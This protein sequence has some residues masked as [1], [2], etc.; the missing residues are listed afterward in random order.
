VALPNYCFCFVFLHSKPLL[1]FSN[2]NVVFERKKGPKKIG[3]KSNMLLIKKHS[4]NYGNDYI[5]LF[6][7]DHLERERERE[8][9][10]REKGE[11]EKEREREKREKRKREKGERERKR[12]AVAC[13][14]SAAC[15]GV[16]GRFS[17]QPTARRVEVLQKKTMVLR[18]TKILH[19]D[20]AK[21]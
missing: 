2:E 13:S 15:L 9:R 5:Y 21:L 14:I 12:C 6:N 10:E 19:G 3:L 17:V 16:L 1:R 18:K 8:K 4:V 11:R 20:S 7:W